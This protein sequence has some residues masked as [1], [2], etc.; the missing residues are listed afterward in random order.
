[1]DGKEMGERGGVLGREGSRVREGERVRE[2]LQRRENIFE[3]RGSNPDV[4][5]T[6]RVCNV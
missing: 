4:H 1:M 3:V 6:L 5:T 2:I